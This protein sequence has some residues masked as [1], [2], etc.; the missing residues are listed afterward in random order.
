MMLTSSTNILMCLLVGTFHGKLNLPMAHPVKML[1]N[2]LWFAHVLCGLPCGFP[3]GRPC[4]APCGRDHRTDR[5]VGVLRKG[6]FAPFPPPV[7]PPS[8]AHFSCLSVWLTP[9]SHR[10]WLSASETEGKRNKPSTCKI[11][12]CHASPLRKIRHLSWLRSLGTTPISGKTLSE[13]KGHS[14]SSRR[15]PGYS[16]SSSRNWKFHSRNTK[17]HSRNGL[18]RLDQYETH[19]SRS[20]SRSDS[21]NCREPTRKI[22]ICPLHSR[23]VF[24]RIGVVPAHQIDRRRKRGFHCGSGRQFRRMFMTLLPGHRLPP[25]SRPS[26]RASTS[27]ESTSSRFPVLFCRFKPLSG[28]FASASC[29]N[30]IWNM[31]GSH[32]SSRT[33]SEPPV[34]MNF[35]GFSL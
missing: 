14:Q 24:S 4:E 33:T 26:S 23:S 16:R 21:R 6:V 7:A 13:W 29:Q 17:F 18:S 25:P 32:T 28:F 5:L 15:V 35:P 19:N 30:P 20:N 9:P 27:K 1:P 11:F 34:R 8:S 3:C 10:Y 31:A 2:K 22:F 12:R